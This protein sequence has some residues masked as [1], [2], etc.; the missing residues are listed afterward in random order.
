MTSLKP[1]LHSILI[2][3]LHKQ[4]PIRVFNRFIKQI[5]GGRS[6]ADNEAVCTMR[7]LESHPHSY[8]NPIQRRHFEAWVELTF[9]QGG[10]SKPLRRDSKNP[11]L[12][13]LATQ[14]LLA[15][16]KVDQAAEW[17]NSARKSWGLTQVG[18]SHP[19]LVPPKGMKLDVEVR[20]YI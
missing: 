1:A 5:E 19:S 18:F 4:T 12:V 7:L 9:T 13:F 20:Y 10:I 14:M 8:F 16:G 15:K 17:V 3:Q 11:K 6:D 2:T